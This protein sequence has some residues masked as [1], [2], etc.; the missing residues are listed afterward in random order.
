MSD[1]TS[2]TTF[3]LYYYGCSFTKL[4]LNLIICYL[5]TAEPEPEVSDSSSD[6]TPVIIGVVGGVFILIV[7]AVIAVVIYRRKCELTA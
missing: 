2:S 7:V 5:Y 1:L 6:K 3:G 4:K